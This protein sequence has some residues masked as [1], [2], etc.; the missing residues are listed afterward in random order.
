MQCLNAF[1]KDIDEGH[2]DAVFNLRSSMHNV[3]GNYEVVLTGDA[4]KLL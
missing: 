4:A 2:Y 3:S 1:Q